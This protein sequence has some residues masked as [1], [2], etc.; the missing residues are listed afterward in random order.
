MGVL[1]SYDDGSV[2]FIKLHYGLSDC[3]ITIKVITKM[4]YD[5]EQALTSVLFPSL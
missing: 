2:I 1:Q 5:V 3:F 4:S